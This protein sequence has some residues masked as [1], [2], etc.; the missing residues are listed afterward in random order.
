MAVWILGEKNLGVAAV[1]LTGSSLTCLLTGEGSTRA[2]VLVTFWLVWSVPQWQK[3][4]GVAARAPQRGQ[5]LA[6]TAWAWGKI[7]RGQ[8]LG[9]SAVLLFLFNTNFMYKEII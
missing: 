7:Q 1:Q 6:G 8:N 3:Y 4:V 9:R 5:E 2:V